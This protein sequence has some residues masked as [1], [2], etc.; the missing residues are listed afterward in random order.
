LLLL[1]DVFNQH[2]LH[3]RTRSCHLLGRKLVIGM[4]S[5]FALRQ[6]AF[7]GRLGQMLREVGLQTTRCTANVAKVHFLVFEKIYDFNSQRMR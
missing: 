5:F 4:Q 2:L 1:L 3:D 7:V 6:N